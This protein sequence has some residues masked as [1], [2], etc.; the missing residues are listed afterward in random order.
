MV[1]QIWKGKVRRMFV[2]LLHLNTAFW[3]IFANLGFQLQDK[4]K[5][6]GPL[7]KFM[8][9]FFIQQF[10]EEMVVRPPK[11]FSVIHCHP[12]RHALAQVMECTYSLVYALK[13]FK[14]D[15]DCDLFLGCLE[16]LLP[17]DL[18]AV[19]PVIT[20]DV[21]TSCRKRD[22]RVHKETLGF[23]SLEEL[24]RALKDV[25]IFL[26]KSDEAFLALQ[27][28]VMPLS[29]LLSRRCSDDYSRATVGCAGSG[30]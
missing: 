12:R 28:H 29:G 2:R 18:R 23:L 10:G 17:Q 24:L 16:K 30:S 20:N 5:S 25:K 19:Q 21:L 14:Y 11:S 13:K 22:L 26:Y 9:S 4:Q 7:D 8:L 3:N 1:H 27:V 15:P 6:S